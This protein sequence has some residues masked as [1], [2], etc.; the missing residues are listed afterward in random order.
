MPEDEIVLTYKYVHISE[1]VLERHINTITKELMEPKAEAEVLHTEG[2]EGD[3]YK[4]EPKTYEGFDLVEEKL[5]TNSEGTYGDKLITVT[6]EYI[7]K[8]KVHVRYIDAVTKEDIEVENPETGEME[9]L[10]YTIPGHEGEHY[11][12]QSK[13]IDGYVLPELPENRTGEM[14]EEPIEVIYEYRKLS[15]GVTV[16]YLNIL[17]NKEPVLPSEKKNGYEGESY[18]TEPK[19]VPGFELVEERLPENAEGFYTEEP[20]TVNYYYKELAKVII[21]Y[22]DAKTGKEIVIIKE[23][24]PLETREEKEGYIG[25]NYI[26]EEKEIPGY[27]LVKEPDNKTGE[28]EEAETV[29]IYTYARKA[30]VMVRYLE[31]DKVIDSEEIEGYAGK[32]YTTKPQDIKYYELIEDKLPSNSQGTMEVEV[33]ED[34]DVLNDTIYVD[35]VYRKKTFNLKVEKRI[36]QIIV[37]ESPRD[38][39][40]EI[41]KVEINKQLMNS[42][43]VKVVYAIKVT[44]DGELDG[45]ATIVESI[46]SGMK[47]DTYNDNDWVQDGISIIRHTETIKPGKMNEY[48]IILDFIP[49]EDNLGTKVN[50][51]S[52]EK[53]ENAAGFEE[54]SL[55][56]NSAKADV[57]I[58]V[59]TGKEE[60]NS[61]IEIAVLITLLFSIGV[62]IY[63][64]GKPNNNE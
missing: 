44:N 5:P 59:G 28:M 27:I 62:C 21:K 19:N 52:L 3:P 47:L 50:I 18:K 49:T 43:N 30:K 11:D 58:I 48:E 57:I 25:D 23:G 14:T 13:Q 60:T 53:L 10:S 41:G 1:G 34:G 38:I 33:S 39:N 42:A 15:G 61:I 4:I 31:G 51:V 12:T 64:L 37:N 46:P 8:A 63:Y 55:K 9:K 17:P 45:S 35:Y 54:I 6:Y 22:I 24:E 36:K 2:D 16:N 40:D 56:D 26:S 32:E 7:R 29:I 20:I